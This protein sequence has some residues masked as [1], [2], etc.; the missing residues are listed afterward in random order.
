MIKNQK[1]SNKYSLLFAVIFLFSVVLGVHNAILFFPNHGFDGV[2]HVEYIRYLYENHQLP[3][4]TGLETHQPPIYYVLSAIVLSITQ[5]IKS[6]QFVNIFILW[7]IIYVVWKCVRLIFHNPNQGMIAA[8]SLAALPMLNIFPPMVTNELLNTF[9]II[10]SVVC[11][12]YLNYISDKKTYNLFFVLML[13]CLVFG[14]W[15][16]ISIITV[17]PTIIV[18]LY[19]SAKSF[20]NFL[21]YSVITLFTFVLAYTPIYLRASHSESPSNIVH[22]ANK[23]IF[24]R[25]PEFYYRLDWIPK[26]DMYTTQYYSFLGGAWNSFWSDG[27]N[28]ITPFVSFHKKA[29]ILWLLGFVLFPLT[30]YGQFLELKKNRK[31]FT[32]MTTLGLSMFVFYLLLNMVSNHYSAVRLTYQMGIVLPYAYGLASASKN[33]KLF[34]LLLILLA[35][36]FFVMVSFYWMLPWWSQAQP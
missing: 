29:L 13:L 28:V 1:L 30:L 18:G 7:A 10:S 17:I 24:L 16:K 26:V 12:I 8:I 21:F 34:Y 27:H 15:T 23:I 31:I 36:Q 9:W 11:V 19:F 20:K 5:N 35:V 2:G 22:T 33:K 4:P 14:V 6:I 3:P 25:S 32:I